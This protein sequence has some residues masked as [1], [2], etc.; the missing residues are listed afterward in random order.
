MNQDLPHQKLERHFHEPARL[1]I[2]CRLIREPDGIA[3]PRLREELDLTFGNLD[4]HLKVLHDAHVIETEKV[5]AKRRPQSII[6]LTEQ[7][8]A[9]FLQYLDHLERMLQEAAE[10]RQALGSHRIA[11]GTSA[12]PEPRPA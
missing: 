4:R 1:A 11:P 8:R 3:F 2:L 9:E 6:R 12:L 5:P 7:G 10:A